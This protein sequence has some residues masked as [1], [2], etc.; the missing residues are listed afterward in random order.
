MEKN[1]IIMSESREFLFAAPIPKRKI[2]L[3]DERY[4]MS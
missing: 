4:L 1:K 3:G 2:K